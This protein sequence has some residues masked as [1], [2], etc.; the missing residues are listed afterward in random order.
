[1]YGRRTMLFFTIENIRERK[2]DWCAVIIPSC[3]FCCTSREQIRKVSVS[4]CDRFYFPFHSVCCFSREYI[5]IV[6][7]CSFSDYDVVGYFF[8]WLFDCGNSNRTVKCSALCL[9][10]VAC[11]F[12]FS[13]KIVHK[14][15]RQLWCHFISIVLL[16][17]RCHTFVYSMKR[18]RW[19][20]FR[21][22]WCE[23]YKINTRFPFFSLAVGT[24]KMFT[25]IAN[26]QNKTKQSQSWSQFRNISLITI[27]I[28]QTL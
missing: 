1:M 27:L 22:I 4:E 15:S 19:F 25:Q 11:C 8:F 9:K 23:N 12:F 10:F 5:P 13:N 20:L 17:P 24:T 28:V 3:F 6:L 14:C 7:L 21:S 18:W 2:R 26:R 16:A